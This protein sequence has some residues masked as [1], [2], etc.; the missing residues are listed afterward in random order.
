MNNSDLWN[1]YAN[2]ALTGVMR[3]T[4]LTPTFIAERAAQIADRMLAAHKQRAEVRT[5]SPHDAPPAPPLPTRTAQGDQAPRRREWPFGSPL[6]REVLPK[7]DLP[8]V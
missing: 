4:N 1:M 5:T 8:V 2:T 3:N 6:D 7:I